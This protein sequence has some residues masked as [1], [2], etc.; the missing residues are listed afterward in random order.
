MG[1]Q[2]RDWYREHAAK[3]EAES[4][5]PMIYSAVCFYCRH[6]FR[7]RIPGSAAA[8]PTIQISCNCPKCG[9]PYSATVRTSEQKVTKKENDP[10]RIGGIILAVLVLIA[11]V[12]WAVNRFVGIPVF[13]EW[14]RSDIW[15]SVNTDQLMVLL[16]RLIVL[17]ICMPVHESAHAWAALKLGDPTGKN[18]GRI[19]LNPF[20]HLDFVGTLAIFLLGVGYAKPVPVNINRFKNK[21]RDFALTSL[22]GTLSNLLMAVFCLAL[23]KLVTVFGDPNA[24]D[25]FIVLLLTYASFINVSLAVFNLIPVP[26]LDGSRLFMA[27]LPDRLY[28]GMLKNE[29][30]I[31]VVLIVVLIFLGQVGISPIGQVSGIVFNSLFNLIM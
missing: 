3:R 10:A 29:R 21:K 13:K 25:Y 26:P 2:D 20:R 8:N 27:V 7:I 15:K 14:V 5:A 1:I 6:S 30:M 24:K 31:S 18:Q 22:A 23:L 16:A 4:G 9:R 11:L 19:S 12:L 28:N 17:L